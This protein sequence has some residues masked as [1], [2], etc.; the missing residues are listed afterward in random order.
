MLY[1]L[2]EYLHTLFV[3]AGSG[4]RLQMIVKEFC[5]GYY[6]EYGGK[7]F[8]ISG[9]NSQGQKS[10]KNILVFQS[11]TFQVNHLFTGCR[12]NGILSVEPGS[13]QSKSPRGLTGIRWL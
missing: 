4:K 3:T 11:H 2:K 9:S 1:P 7:G 13:L 8:R 5:S 12:C 6:K 10:G